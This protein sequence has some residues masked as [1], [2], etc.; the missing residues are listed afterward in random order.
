VSK[1][2][3]LKIWQYIYEVRSMKQVA[4]TDIDAMMKHEEL[5]WLTLVTCRGYDAATNSYRYRV[6]VRAVLVEVK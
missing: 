2:P 5:P 3:W 6:I 1:G 4:P